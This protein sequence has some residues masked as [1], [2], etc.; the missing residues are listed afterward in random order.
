M[1]QKTTVKVYKY[2]DNLHYE[3]TADV[4]EANEKYVLLK[5]TP[6]RKLIHHSRKNIY[7]YNN[8]SI[9]FFP[10]DSAYTVNIDIEKN[11]KLK[12]YCNVCLPSQYNNQI[13]SFIDLDI[14]YVRDELGNWK[15][16]DL[17]DFEKN[18]IVMNYSED[19]IFQA[20][21]AL[22]NLIAR[23]EL[24]EFPFDGFLESHVNKVLKEVCN[25]VE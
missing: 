14:D 11:G 9:E 5:G 25:D 7:E 20:E 22:E 10:L 19:I 12:Y 17:E 8:H 4:I 6:G 23:V 15:V 1:N 16:I 13:L 3:W 18:K 24:K 21:L 2:N